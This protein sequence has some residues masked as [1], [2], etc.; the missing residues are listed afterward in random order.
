MLKIIV[1]DK[2]KLGK[3]IVSLRKQKGWSQAELGRKA[4]VSRAFICNLERGV[5]GDPGLQKLLNILALF[6]KTLEIKDIGEPPTLD[7]LL[8]EQEL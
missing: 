2:Q 5:G 3:K 4:G 1:M 6:S 8:E 7:D